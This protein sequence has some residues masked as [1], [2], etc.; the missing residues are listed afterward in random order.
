MFIKSEIYT[1]DSG[2][3]MRK[4]YYGSIDENGT[5]IVTTTVESPNVEPTVEPTQLDRIE[6]AVTKSQEEIANNAIDTYTMELIE[7][8]VL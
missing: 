6:A 5:E 3:E 7:G 8:G 4:E 1:N 2:V